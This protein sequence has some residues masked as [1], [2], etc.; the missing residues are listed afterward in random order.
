MEYRLNMP[1]LLLLL[2][3]VLHSCLFRKKM[4]CIINLYDG[5]KYCRLFVK[6][7]MVIELEWNDGH[8]RRDGRKLG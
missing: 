4:S 7:G 8:Q 3:V 1:V 2:M 5:N 6:K